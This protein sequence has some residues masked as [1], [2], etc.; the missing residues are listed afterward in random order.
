MTS[1]QTTI[2]WDYSELAPWYEL[3]APYATAALEHLLRDCGIATDSHVVEIGAG[4]GRLTRWL[5]ARGKRVDAIEP[6]GPMREIGIALA[7]PAVRWHDGTGTATGLDDGCA[8]LVAYGSSFNVLEPHAAIAEA[9][10]LLGDD[11]HVL[12]LYNHRALDDELQ[13][14]TEALFRAHIPTYSGGSRRQDPLPAWA[15]HAR[16]SAVR[17]G[18]ERIRVR[19]PL[20]DFVDGFRAH[21]T[22][23]R[24][25]GDGLD[26]LLQRLHDALAADC[27]DGIIEVPFDTR[28]WCFKVAP[29]CR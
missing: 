25:L 12:L 10:R 15:A 16:V 21:G 27:A 5:S 3:R 2:D 20:R 18:A 1:V 29:P 17:E 9:L 23:I 13:A 8:Q 26:A 24:Q 14:R 19:Q 11:G 22:L 28:A 4:T 6:C 7:P